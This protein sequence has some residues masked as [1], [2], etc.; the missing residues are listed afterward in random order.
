MTSIRGQ[1]CL[2][3]RSQA[4]KAPTRSS[5]NKSDNKNHINPLGLNK[6]RRPKALLRPPETLVRSETSAKPFTS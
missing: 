4:S 1:S 2:G 3:Q 6:L 5:S